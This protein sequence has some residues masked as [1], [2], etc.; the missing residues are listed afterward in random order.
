MKKKTQKQRFNRKYET[1]EEYKI[2]YIFTEGEETEPNYFECKKKEIRSS[3][4]KIKIKGVGHN[5]VS[6]VDYAKEFVAIMDIKIDSSMGGDECWVVFDKDNYN[7]DFDRAISVAESAGFKVA[8]SNECFELWLLLHFNFIDAAIGR[9]EY[10]EKLDEK[11]NKINGQDY[12]KNS[13]NMYELIAHLEKDAI[14]NAKK[15]LETHKGVQ[16]ALKRNPSTTVH[17][18]VERLNA[19]KK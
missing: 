19:L 13:K 17:S 9:K 1:R 4:V 2:V 14:R 12:Q 11:I 5:T 8:Y 6:L 3:N 16:S 7:A 15:L 10:K 18:L